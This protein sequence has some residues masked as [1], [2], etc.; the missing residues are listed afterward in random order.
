MP[1]ASY[2]LRDQGKLTPVRDQGNFGTCWT[3]ATY[4]S[5]ESC[6]LPGETW[7]FSENNLAWNAGYDWGF[8][9]GGNYTM[10]NAY[11]G[12]WDGPI[13]ES[14]D[15]YGS[16]AHDPS[17]LTKQKHVQDVLVLAPK[18]GTSSDDIKN[19]LMTYGAIGTYVY[20]NDS[21]YASGSASYYYPGSEDS[22]H[23]VTIVGWDDSYAASNFYPT[24]PGN[25]AFIIRNS[26]GPS[27]GDGG[28][29]YCSYYDTWAGVDAWC[30]SGTEA[31]SNYSGIYD[32]DPLGCTTYVGWSGETSVYLVNSFTADKTENITAAAVYAAYAGTAYE[33]W[34]GA[35][36]TSM[37]KRGTGVFT[38]AGYH[39]VDLSTPLPVSSGQAFAVGFKVTGAAGEE[40]LAPCEY[41]FDGWSSGATAAA[42]QSSLSFDGSTWYDLVVDVYANTNLCVKAFAGG[43]A[44]PVDPHIDALSPSH[45][46]AGSTVVIMG[47][48]LGASGTVS[49]GGTPAST[50]SWASTAIVATVP[51]GSGTVNV[52]VSTGGKTSNAVSFTYDA[53]PT[54]PVVTG[55]SPNHGTAGTTVVITGTNLGTSGTVNFGGA[56]A[57]TSTWASTA[58]VATAPAGSGTVQVTVSTGGKT[59]N[60]MSFTYDAPPTDP[61]VTMSHPQHGCRRQRSRDH[62]HQPRHQRHGLLRRDQRCDRELERHGDRRYGAERSRP[63][64]GERHRRDRG[65]DL[66]RHHLHR[67]RRCSPADLHIQLSR[68][69]CQVAQPRPAGDLHRHRHRRRRRRAALLRRRQHLV[70]HGPR[71][72]R[73]AQLPG[74]GRP[75]L[76]RRHDDLLQGP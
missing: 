2:D 68:R 44:P 21:Y 45:G 42:G 51:A 24:P 48:D 13:R 57:S 67:H 58:I 38:N 33:V 52:T 7:D 41:P 66:E 76:G 25:G 55:V 64:A 18:N 3:F 73:H 8:D 28:Y 75:L 32:Y 47:T 20:W 39:T 12:R 60:G 61:V 1:P 9:E 27:W 71:C 46:T 43:S 62:R 10:S 56:S 63:R 59:S 54:D 74:R 30:F 70:R 40:Y 4:G 16:G 22:N 34:A 37:T 5:M 19:A 31:T 65:Q 49:F 14:D 6:L 23:A 17:G 53:P 35:S 11:L 29:F 26:W 36:K 50:S 72:L 15:A 69:P